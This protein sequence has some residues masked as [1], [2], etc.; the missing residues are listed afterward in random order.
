[1]IDRPG[2][3]NVF[4]LYASADE[5]LKN[6]LENHLS[7]LQHHG[8]IDLWHEGQIEPGAERDQ[9]VGEFIQKAH[10]ILLLISAN[11]LAPDCYTRY[12]PE[13]R[14]AYERQKLG[15][16]RII[17]VILRHCM[18]QLD[19]LAGLNPLPKGGHPV[20]SKHWESSD[21]AFRD[22]VL[23]LQQTAQDLMQ[24]AKQ[25]PRATH[26]EATHADQTHADHETPKRAESARPE[27]S[28]QP[29][30]AR[31]RHAYGSELYAEASEPR[32][33]A[34]ERKV[35]GA[36]AAASSR[37]GEAERLINDLFELLNQ[38]DPEHS[39]SMVALLL[40]S[41]LLR[42]GSLDQT[43]RKNRFNHAR[44]RLV[45]Y[46]RP[47]EI[48][49]RKPTG[50]TGVGTLAHREEGDEVSYVIARN[51]GL[52]GLPGHVRIF[53]PKQGGYPRISGVSL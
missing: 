11:F 8:Y 29:E 43:F 32:P 49:A 13:L 14:A 34:S 48:L 42:N 40:H 10:I 3:I 19:I 52:G 17:P 24:A 16:V 2:N 33:G 41:S 21:V 25:M 18:W 22:V 6:E 44:E 7:L 26:A 30:S 39:A 45:L 36:D 4:I 15:E 50:R 31:E 53:F 27:E 23:T 1:M 5:E 20:R 47:V 28:R 51:D 37:D 35:T 38:P 46:R 12:E 9:V